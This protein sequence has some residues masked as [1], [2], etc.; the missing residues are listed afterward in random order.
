MVRVAGTA[1]DI[2]QSEMLCRW[3]SFVLYEPMCRWH[4]KLFCHVVRRALFI[5]LPKMARLFRN[6][7]RTNYAKKKTQKER[8]KMMQYALLLGTYLL[9]MLTGSLPVAGETFK[10]TVRTGPR[11]AARYYAAHD[12]D[13]RG[14]I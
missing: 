7:V 2:R 3:H 13:S 6:T 14:I 8:R 10:C 5:S 11:L 9:L 1:D 12:Q 4:K